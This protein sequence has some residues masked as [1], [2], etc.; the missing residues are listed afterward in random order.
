[1]FNKYTYYKEKATVVK[2]KEVQDLEIARK[3]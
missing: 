2:W 3:T 1:M